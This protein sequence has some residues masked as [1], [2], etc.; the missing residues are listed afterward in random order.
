MSYLVSGLGADARGVGWSLYAAPRGYSLIPEIQTVSGKVR[1]DLEAM[2]PYLPSEVREHWAETL[3]THLELS[4][5]IVPID[6]GHVEDLRNVAQEAVD[7]L[8]RAS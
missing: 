5:Q 7:L 8:R 2:A 4:R 1:A 3:E 6:R